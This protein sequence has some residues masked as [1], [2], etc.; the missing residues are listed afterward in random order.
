MAQSIFTS[1]TPAVTDASDDTDYTLGTLWHSDVAGEALRCRWRFPTILP[2]QTVIG[3]IFRYTNESTGV[4]LARANFVN[5]IAGQWNLSETFSS[6]VSI[7]P[8]PTRYIWAIWT[9]DHYVYTLNFFTGNSVVNENLTAP[10]DDTVTPRR[11]GRGEVTL[12][13]PDY[14]GSFGPACYFAD[15]VFEP[16]GGGSQMG[17]QAKVGRH[18][19][20]LQRKT[21]GGNTEYIKRRPSIITAVNVDDTLNIRVGHHGETYTNV[22]LRSGSALFSSYVTY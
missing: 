5:P 10:A 14:P 3:L 16:A 7:D 22:P 2:T 11:N 21:F 8:F 18:V 15:G 6:A 12:V 13:N 9:S 4:E 17:W 19:A 20:Y 1:Q